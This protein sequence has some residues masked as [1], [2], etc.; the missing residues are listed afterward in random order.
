MGVEQFNQTP[1]N[2][3]PLTPS[4]SPS[5]GERVAD[6]P[7]E[8]LASGLT[9]YHIWKRSNW[10]ALTLTLPMNLVAADVSPLHLKPGKRESLLTSAATVQGFKARTLDRRILSPSDGG[11]DGVGTVPTHG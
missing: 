11:R 6:R 4:L 5:D 2:G 3:E 1:H 7:G 9:L 10:S 8:G